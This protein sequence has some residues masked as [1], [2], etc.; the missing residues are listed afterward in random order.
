M[1]WGELWRRLWRLLRIWWRPPPPSCEKCG[2]PKRGELV[3][4]AFG[5]L[6]VW[7]CADCSCLTFPVPCGFVEA[8][9]RWADEP[10][11]DMGGAFVNKPPDL[12]Q[13]V[14]SGT[15]AATLPPRRRQGTPIYVFGDPRRL[16]C[17]PDL[18]PDA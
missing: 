15:G 16:G 11:A 13:P 6:V 7:K 8:V 14:P 18:E 3:A 2:M 17:T 9:G 1:T 12:V 5:P 4:T 10:S